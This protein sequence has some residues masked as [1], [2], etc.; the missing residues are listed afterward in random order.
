MS[1]VTE[2]PEHAFNPIAEIPQAELDVA[3]QEW[4]SRPMAEQ[5]AEQERLSQEIQQISAH[6]VQE[7]GRM[8]GRPL[9]SPILGGAE[10]SLP[11]RAQQMTRR[12]AVMHFLTQT[13]AQAEVAERQMASIAQNL[14]GG[15]QPTR[16][17]PQQQAQQLQTGIPGSADGPPLQLS[18]A[19]LVDPYTGLPVAAVETDGLFEQVLQSANIDNLERYY[20]EPLDSPL[21]QSLARQQR[22]AVEANL[23]YRLR[24]ATVTTSAGITAERAP[25]RR[26]VE[27][28][29]RMPELLDYIPMEEEPRAVYTYIAETVR[30]GADPATGAN[31]D[32]AAQKNEGVLS[33]AE[34]DFRDTRR[35]VNI[36]LIEAHST[37]TYEQLANTARA[38]RIIEEKL[39]M[40]IDQVIDK[41]ALTD[42]VGLTGIGVIT[43]PTTGTGAGNLRIAKPSDML[44]RAMIE[45]VF[46]TGRTRANLGVLYPDFYVDFLTEQ[47]EAGGYL[48]RSS[49]ELSPVTT[50][51]G[52]PTVM[53]THG[54]SYGTTGNPAA[55]IGN[56]AEFSVL[57][58]AQQAMFRLLDQHDDDALKLTFRFQAW[59]RA[60][61]VYFRAVA[62]CRINVGTT[63]GG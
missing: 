10:A 35:E 37:V 38:R 51:W 33:T 15:Q 6:Q 8:V 5:R 39:P 22:L 13:I 31:A 23:S 18:Q 9:E 52:L 27:L 30:S 56:F 58:Y 59:W 17:T 60:I 40:M 47:S 50:A 54:V 25:D 24:Q 57:A 2:T 32:K 11:E 4:G 62:F 20:E 41:K 63:P 61:V 29:T 7:N 26:R 43:A 34:A 49:S 21:I 53:A 12:V 3:A 36:P 28:P 1:E 42:L 45:E 46:K 44:I 16:L 55:V 48:I 14:G 19:G